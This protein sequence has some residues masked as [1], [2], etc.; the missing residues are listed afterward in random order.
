MKNFWSLPLLYILLASPACTNE[1]PPV[2]FSTGNS[3]SYL[4]LKKE[5]LRGW[6]TWNT[7]SFLFYVYLPDGLSVN[8][9]LKD[10]KSSEILKNTFVWAGAMDKEVIWPGPHAIDGS[11]TE[12]LLWWKGNGMVVKTASSGEDLVAAIIPADT[13]ENCGNLIIQPCMR[14]QMRSK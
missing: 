10:K 12:L 4:R 3:E 5:L 8:F 1:S 9:C 14:L 7:Y 6:N 13:S 11:Y 2:Q